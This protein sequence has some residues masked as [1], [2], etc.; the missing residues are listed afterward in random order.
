MWSKNPP[1]KEGLYRCCRVYWYGDK[2]THLEHFNTRV[3]I[4]IFNGTKNYGKLV[5][6]T[7]LTPVDQV[8]YIWWDA[9]LEE[10][11][12]DLNLLKSFYNDE[13][14]DWSSLKNMS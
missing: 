3:S 6:S 7:N 2:K 4:N 13:D 9:P 14:L 1:Q 5:T 8:D 11:D 10:Q 12:I